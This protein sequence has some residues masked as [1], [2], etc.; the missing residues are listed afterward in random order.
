MLFGGKGENPCRPRVLN[1]PVTR[2][3][4]I[5]YSLSKDAS[6]SAM[7]LAS[8]EAAVALVGSGAGDDTANQAFADDMHRRL[9][10]DG[11]A[12]VRHKASALAPG[13][14]S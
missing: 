3:H 10:E 9:T 7:R 8:I 6:H 13:G 4:Q 14:S 2:C 12:T 1:I 5:A 11:Q